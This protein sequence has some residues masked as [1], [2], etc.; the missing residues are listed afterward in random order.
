MQSESGYIDAYKRAQ[1]ELPE[2]GTLAA[3]W[4]FDYDPEG[5]DYLAGL[6]KYLY[7]LKRFAKKLSRA[8]ALREEHFKLFIEGQREED[9]GH[10]NWRLAMNRAAQ[11]AEQTL[12]YHTE[13]Y[14]K[15][16]DKK[17]KQ[18]EA[19]PIEK[20]DFTIQ[21]VDRDWKPKE[22]VQ[23]V[24][25]PKL[26][27]RQR[28]E[29]SRLAKE[30]NRKKK[31][32]EDKLVDEHVDDFKEEY[33]VME[34]PESHS[35]YWAGGASTTWLEV[36]DLLTMFITE[37]AVGEV[38]RQRYGELEN[39]CPGNKTQVT[40][41]VEDMQRVTTLIADTLTDFL[42]SDYDLDLADLFLISANALKR[43][44]L[45]SE[46]KSFLHRDFREFFV[47]KNIRFDD[48]NL[49]K[50]FIMS[51]GTDAN[52]E[53]AEDECGD[54]K[55]FTHFLKVVSWIAPIKM[56]LDSMNDIGHIVD[57]KNKNDALIMAKLNNDFTENR[58]IL[59]KG[60]PYKVK[61]FIK[62]FLSEWRKEKNTALRVAYGK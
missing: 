6:K 44:T 57:T 12:Q 56:H 47:E 39:M 52:L 51:C 20:Q 59:P 18:W 41:T 8:A 61:T 4:V 46:Y 16:L 31:E 37:Y 26:S 24:A 49:D 40:G 45:D 38:T 28:K 30:A 11:H 62:L 15:Y 32:Q 23:K 13:K 34:I 5:G 53:L 3:L 55:R 42:I 60:T 29:I 14:D 54:D 10:K 48:L 25:R 27:E 43:A 7:E 9:D 2:A 17:I 36:H 58:V 35:A 21:N 50:A 1:Y 19:R 33:E 22:K